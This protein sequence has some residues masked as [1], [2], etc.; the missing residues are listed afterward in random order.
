MKDK[1]F[2]MTLFVS[3]LALLFLMAGI[4]YLLL[5]QARPAFEHFGFFRFIGSSEW[6]PENGQYGA[7]PF[8]TGTLL[9]ASLA[10]IICIPF[11][12]SLALFVGDLYKGRKI[13]FRL[14]TFIDV[15]A[16]TPSVIL[17]IWGYYSLRPFFAAL[18]IGH[19]GYGILPATILLALMIVPYATSMIITFIAAVPT[20]LKEGA[21]CLG[22]TRFEVIRNISIP[23]AKK[24]IMSAYALALG[25]VLGET[26][27]VTIIIGNS[28]H[29]P[30]GINDIGNTLA[31]VIFNQFETADA[32]KFS[33]L[34]AIALLLFLIT[35]IVNLFARYLLRRV[36]S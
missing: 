21:Y 20:Q 35:A 26:I 33:F 25:R 3:T 11:S 4:L 1:V 8:L 27:I 32:L 12:L 7:L 28:N 13:A 16:G 15:L 30:S 10:L 29:F 5:S 17:G 18:H 36:V 6:N 19:Q 22:A 23:F 24:G 2:K 34:F 9:T 14:N 31:S